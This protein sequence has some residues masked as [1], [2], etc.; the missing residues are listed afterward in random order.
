[1]IVNADDLAMT[2]G[3]NKA[4][5]DG[6]DRGAITHTSIMANGDYFDE[7]MAGM[8][9]RPDLGL[10][11]HLNL[12]YGKA[13][14]KERSYCDEEGYFNMG[15]AALL[16]R[17]DQLFLDAL[18]KEFEAQIERVLADKKG[19][20]HLTHLDSHRHIH[21]IPHIYPIVAQLA[22]K[23]QIPRVRLINEDMIESITL[24]RRANFFLNGGIVKYLLLRTFSLMD[25]RKADLY[26]GMRFYSIL[27]TGVV[28]ADI[29]RKLG[30]SPVEYEVMVHPGYPEM[31][32][33]IS[34]YDPDEKS[35]RISQDRL[36]ELETVLSLAREG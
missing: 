11:I 21:L 4:I 5:F 3:T 17:R 13:L 27:Y 22:E 15:Y 31:D 12:T 19:G 6:Y 25:A 34:F 30:N 10:G 16:R 8:A 7:A 14:I 9:E 26:R 23:Y 1:M 20:N 24:T 36:K 2:P 18:E 29:L 32:Q 33:E 35:Y 28:H